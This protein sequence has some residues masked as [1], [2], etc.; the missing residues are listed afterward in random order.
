MSVFSMMNPFGDSVFDTGQGRRA[1]NAINTGV[2]KIS[3]TLDDALSTAL[4]DGWGSTQ[5]NAYNTGTNANT[6]ALLDPNSASAWLNPQMDLMLNKAGQAVQGGAGAGLQSSAANN[7][8]SDRVGG[9]A[10]EMWQQALNNSNNAQ[11]MTSDIYQQQF[12]NNMLP[13][14]TRSQAILDMATSKANAYGSMYGTLAGI[15]GQSRG[16]L[17]GFG[18]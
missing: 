4:P 5:L 18:L 10:G 6:A 7:A 11:K 13:D 17:S 15:Q 2:D 3:S 9:M 8:I 16:L 1:T 14:M 12:E